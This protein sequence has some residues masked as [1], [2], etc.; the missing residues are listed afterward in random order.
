MAYRGRN[1]FSL[2]LG[3]GKSLGHNHVLIF[4]IFSF[5]CESSSPRWVYELCPGKN[6]R[7]FHE[8][9][10]LSGTSTSTTAVETEHVLGK[11]VSSIRLPKEDEWKNV[12]NATV[13]HQHSI[14]KIK[15]QPRGHHG[16]NGA[17]FFQEYMGGDV[18]DHADVTGSAIKAGEVGEG[19]V[20]RSTTVKYG[21]GSQ[22]EM[23]VKEDTT[24]H[25]V[26]YVNIPALCHHPFFRSPIEKKQVI[27]CLPDDPRG[28][29]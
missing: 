18:C 2:A 24:C 8:V 9:T 27:K 12:V 15:S 4:K 6:I 5:S 13:W 25:Y 29:K 20:E 19:L 23:T 7:Q 26:A 10:L 14:P 16:G 21:C 28:T 17:F 11:F 3:H 1:V 22:I